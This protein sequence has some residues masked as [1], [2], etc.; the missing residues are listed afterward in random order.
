MISVIVLGQPYWGTRIA[1]AL[2]TPSTDMSATFVG[3]KAYL[4]LLARPPRAERVVLMRAGYRV[5]GTTPRGRV[6]DAYWSALRRAMPQ[7]AGC[8][9]WLGSDVMDTVAEARAGT[10]RK[11][12]VASARDDI[13]VADGPWLVTEL[14]EVGLRATDVHVP[15]PHLS[16]DVPPPLPASFRVMT[17]LPG[18]RFDFYGGDV[19]LEAARRLPDVGF[20]VVGRAGSTPRE[21][22]R[23]V[24]WHGWVPG[25]SA[26]YARSTVVVRIPRHD[27]LGA[28]VV[29][30]LLHG[31]HV[32]YS[33]WV[34]YV[35]KLFPVSVPALVNELSSLR[36][37]HDAGNLGLNLEGRNYALAAYDEQ[38]LAER[39]G[40]VIRA[41][42]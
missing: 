8:F 41:R 16:P 36:A 33:Y 21:A 40:V 19:I 27:G 14:A 11:S 28:T 6:F 32:I 5:G 34:P 23:N 35:R 20:D 10:L 39:L 38:S 25:M 13:H 29:E 26:M 17:Y 18:D 15:Q 4:R 42:L 2:N 7:A 24:A 30:G 3:Q 12:A 31:R 9:Y 37:Q 1:Q 22:M